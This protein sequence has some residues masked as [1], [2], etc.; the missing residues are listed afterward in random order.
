MQTSLL[1]LTTVIGWALFHN[2][3]KLASHHLPTPA[4]QIVSGVCWM[5]TLPIYIAMLNK[6]PHKWSWIGVGWCLLAFIATN[7]GTYTYLQVIAKND[8]SK[9]VSIA[10]SYPIVTMLVAIFFM[11]ETLTWQKFL[12]LLLVLS[13]VF[14]S[15]R[16]M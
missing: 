16:S 1:L 5:A 8:V 9:V 7:I 13:G 4:M 10:T 6:T 15:S 12:G 14:V 11:G 2:F 3:V